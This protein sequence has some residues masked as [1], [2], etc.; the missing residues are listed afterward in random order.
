MSTQAKKYLDECGVGKLVE[1]AVTE[2][3][4]T[5]PSPTSTIDF[6]AQH[7]AQKLEESRGPVSLADLDNESWP[8]VEAR[9]EKDTRKM[10]FA[11]VTV[12][13]GRDPG[14]CLDA[15]V[16]G[17]SPKPKTERSMVL[18]H[19]DVPEDWLK[20]LQEAGWQTRKVQHIKY[21]D[22]LYRGGRFA[23]VFTKLRALE[24]TEFGKVLL[25]DTD[26]VVRERIQTS[27]LPGM[28]RQHAGGM[29][30][31]ITVVLKL[32][33]KISSIRGGSRK[34]A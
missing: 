11:Y 2:L 28:L 10:N 32:T 17:E 6:L 22:T 21:K 1:K 4:K 9:V 34:E 20:L 12:V 8:L 7:F 19:C 30:Q 27:C 5:R 26:L 15:A 3:L 33:A 14:Y 23:H 18:L 25:L 13:F 24:L 31:A 16:L 29:P